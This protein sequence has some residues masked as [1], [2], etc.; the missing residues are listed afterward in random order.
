MHDG[1]DERVLQHVVALCAEVLK[2]LLRVIRP[3]G[4]NNHLEHHLV[5]L[6][7]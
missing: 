1:L 7:A 6:A 4:L 5:H 2:Q 3:K